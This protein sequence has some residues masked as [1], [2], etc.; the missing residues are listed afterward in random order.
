M[1]TPKKPAPKP[2]AKPRPVGLPKGEKTGK[3][4]P[5]KAPVPTPLTAEKALT[6]TN[7]DAYE[8][9]K[10]LFKQYDLDSL[11]P[12][13][14]RFIQNGYSSD[15]V[16]LLLTE[17]PAYKQRFSANEARKRAGLPVLSPS[18]Y[19][20][21]E[22]G[23][24]Q[25][26]Q[27]AGLPVGFYDS[28]T[29]FT[30]FLEGDVSPT[31]LQERVNVA[32][33]FVYKSFD[34]GTQSYLSQWYGIGDLV[35]TALDPKVAAPLI[36][37]RLRAATVA[38]PT[39]VSKATAEQIAGTDLS[40]NQLRAASG[41]VASQNPALRKLDNI[42][43]GDVSNDDLALSVIANDAKAT[44]KVGKLAS[45]ERASFSGSSAQS[46]GGLARRDSGSF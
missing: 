32:T 22:R 8:A 46:K 12:D 21:T 42:Y 35:A 1:V 11:A 15:T 29:D 13:I 41:F 25:I 27:A 14:L 4:I 26:M 37:R 43:G 45:K 16:A 44:E 5:Y 33:D 38:G 40:T 17:T 19:I 28:K 31:E 36:E 24:R 9:L 39:G 2:K 23:Y 10:N 30:R 20:S 6:G 7:R 18:E 34:A 3:P